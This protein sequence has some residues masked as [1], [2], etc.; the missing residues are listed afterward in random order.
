[1][2]RAF[3]VLLAIAVHFLLLY[4]QGFLIFLGIEGS[5]NDDVKI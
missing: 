3:R 5:V 4:L 1:M 2:A